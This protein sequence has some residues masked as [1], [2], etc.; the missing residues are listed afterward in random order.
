MLGF[1]L[2]EA[3]AGKTKVG[4][5][6]RN[7]T[8]NFR[9]IK[10]LEAGA[11]E[12][13][14]ATVDMVGPMKLAAYCNLNPD[15]CTSVCEGDGSIENIP[16][17][18]DDYVCE[19]VCK[20]KKFSF[21]PKSGLPKILSI[22]GGAL[23]VVACGILS[24]CLRKGCWCCDKGKTEPPASQG[25]VSGKSFFS[26]PAQKDSPDLYKPLEPSHSCGPTC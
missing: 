7:T 24:C 9:K 16:A 26:S 10:P 19:T 2:L 3:I 4:S 23:A 25:K 13:C 1:L 11:S 5:G 21:C 20:Y 15:Q 6:W 18:C 8:T 14:V 17:D 22:A 12:L